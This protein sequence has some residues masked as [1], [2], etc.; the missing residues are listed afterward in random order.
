MEKRALNSETVKYLEVWEMRKKQPNRVIKVKQ[1]FSGNKI[2][3][4]EILV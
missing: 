1:E 4:E 2:E 3:K